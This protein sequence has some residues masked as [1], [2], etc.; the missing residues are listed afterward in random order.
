M[1]DS[2]APRS[3][4]RRLFLRAGLLVG[5]AAAL[6]GGAVFVRRG[7]SS[8]Q[9]TDAGKEILRAVGNAVL[10]DLL[11]QDTAARQAALDRHIQRTGELL[12]GMPPNL[13]MQ[14]SALLGTLGTLP[15]RLAMTGMATSWDEATVPQVQAA[16]EKLRL[17]PLPMVPAVFGALRDITCLAFFTDSDNWKLAGYGGPL[18]I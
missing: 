11:P 17:S 6:F 8:Q 14:L 7:I 9:L 12:A 1:N 3:P 13:R 2:S 18:D 5:G 10:N 15:G 4:G 16:L